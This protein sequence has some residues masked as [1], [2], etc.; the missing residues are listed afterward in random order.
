M[1]L[2][3]P[4]TGDAP[5]L[6]DAI[7]SSLEALRR[8]MPWAWLPLDL[9]GTVDLLRRFRGDFESGRD[10]VYIGRDRASGVL[11]GCFGVHDRVG[12]TGRELGY[13]I[14]T[15]HDGQG[16]TSE[17]ARALARCLI[18]LEGFDRVE[19]HMDVANLASQRVAAN[20]GCT[21][22]ATLRRRLPFLDEPQR[23]KQVWT[24]FRD[25][26]EGSRAHQQPAEAY[27]ALDR[28]LGLEPT[29]EGLEPTAGGV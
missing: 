26:Y 4:S 18:E 24:L 27:D 14:R 15:G 29:R 19:V 8:F 10:R 9:D 25:T 22:E 17:L 6:V 21:Y 3:A 5:E 23:D 20:V 13:W 7:G 28:P 1:E 2:R 11:L 16:R 12:A